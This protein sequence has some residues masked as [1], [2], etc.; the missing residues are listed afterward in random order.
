M[1]DLVSIGQLSI[2][3][4]DQ[5]RLLGFFEEHRDQLPAFDPVF[6]ERNQIEVRIGGEPWSITA[7][8]TC[9]ECCHRDAGRTV[10]L[11]DDHP[12]PFDFH[13][14]ALL[15]FVLSLDEHSQLN[16]IIL[17]NWILKFVRAGRL[18]ASRHREGYYTCA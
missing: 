12:S 13:P 14:R 4:E 3:I 17:D 15:R 2:L 9:W 7:T 6:P 5:Y 11:R 8:R 16:E 10:V 1:A 18:I